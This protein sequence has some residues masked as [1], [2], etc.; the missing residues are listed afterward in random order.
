MEFAGADGT[1]MFEDVGHSS[2]ARSTMKDYLVGSVKGNG[3][4]K[5]TASAAGSATTTKSSEQAQGG[6]SP[7]AIV[8]LLLAVALGVYFTQSQ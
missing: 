2:E 5:K 1:S 4:A 7:L 3:S 6:L 8:F